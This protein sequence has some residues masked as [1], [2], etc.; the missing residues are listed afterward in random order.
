M[1][2]HIDDQIFC[3]QVRGGVSRYFTELIRGFRSGLIPDVDL[4]A[5][6]RWTVNEHLAATGA[7]IRLPGGFAG[8]RRHV[9]RLNRVHRAYSAFDVVHHTFYD[10]RYL[11]GSYRQA[12]R[13]VSVFDMIPELMP[14]LFTKGNPHEHKRK[15]AE[16][17][18][19]ILCISESTKRDLNSVYG[20]LRAPVHV[21]PLGVNPE[22][23]PLKR[24]LPTLPEKYVLF[25]GDRSRYKDFAVLAEAFA[26][27]RLPKDLSLVAVGGGPLQLE[28]QTLLSRLGLVHRFA[29]RDINESDLP[30]AYSNAVCFVFPSRY[31]GFG[32]PT[33][34][35]MSSGCPVVLAASSAHPEVGGE[36]ALY[37]PP[38]DAAALAEAL[39]ALVAD[40]ALRARLRELGVQRAR[41]FPW[42]ATIELTA[43]AYRAA[44]AVR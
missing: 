18:D 44:L 25:V 2:V 14:E 33:L 13:V 22:F 28:E 15:F 7:A 42:R 41:H 39:N 10:E 3:W 8:R 16:A 36:A 34:E 19:L 29:R 24:V 12:L 21:T 26:V 17:A 23:Q 37:F 43:A 32:L 27:A 1:R 38:G 20:D 31:E 4:V 11:R 40:R 6:A 35:A 9:S 5:P 30:A